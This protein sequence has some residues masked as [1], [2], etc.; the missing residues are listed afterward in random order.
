LFIWNSTMLTTTSQY[1]LRAL[2]HLAQL[3]EGKVMLGKDLAAATDIPPNYLSKMLVALRN[4]GILGTARGTGG[5][6][7]LKKP[8]QEIYLID[9]VELFEAVLRNQ[10]MCL[11]SGKHACSDA[12]PCSAHTIWRDL[13]ATYMGFLVSTPLSALAGV[14][15]AAP[16]QDG[17]VMARTEAANAS[18]SGERNGTTAQ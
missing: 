16:P 3:P 1:A 5:G 9:V 18:H 17:Q 12:A 14:K 6:Y 13:R 4:A 2:A 7:R 11:L 8:P 15:Q 10:S